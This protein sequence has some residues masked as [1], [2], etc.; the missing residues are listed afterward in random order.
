MNEILPKL[1]YAGGFWEENAKPANRLERVH[2]TAAER[3]RGCSNQCDENIVLSTTINT[4]NIVHNYEKNWECTHFEQMETR[5]SS[6]GIS[7]QRRE[8]ANKRLSAIGIRSVWEEVR[9]RR[10]GIRWDNAVGKVRK[11]TGGYRKEIL[12]LEKF[13]GYKT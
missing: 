5:G 11:K 12:P 6:N 9:R 1:E 13:A 7:V 8:D 4:G 10:A 3:I 2:M